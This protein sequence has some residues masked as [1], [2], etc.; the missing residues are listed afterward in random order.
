AGDDQAARQMVVGTDAE[1][2]VLDAWVG[3]TASIKKLREAA[4][5]KFPDK[6]DEVT[7]A[8]MNIDSTKALEDSDVKEE[9]ETPRIV[10]KNPKPGQ[11]DLF[12]KKVDGR[13]VINL[14]ETFKGIT[15]QNVEQMAA[16]MKGWT[17]AS[18]ETAE[19]IEQGQY[20]TPADANQ[21]LSVKMIAALKS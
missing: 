21:A 11:S 17:D 10:A 8:G 18:N 3:Y 9:G 6:A 13:W 19:E 1:K 5:K 20:A 2:Q 4:A 14:S 7:G 12:L 16:M 15:G